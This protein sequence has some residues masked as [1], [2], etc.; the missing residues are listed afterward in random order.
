MYKVTICDQQSVNDKLCDK[1][2]LGSFILSPNATEKSKSTIVS[3][4]V[5]LTDPKP[6]N[7]PINKTGFYCVSTYA[8]SGQDYKGIVTFRNAYGELSAAEIPK[9]AFYGGLAILYAVIGV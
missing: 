7:Y 5:D 3:M 4:A 9:L 2:A 8:Y 6:I 1:S